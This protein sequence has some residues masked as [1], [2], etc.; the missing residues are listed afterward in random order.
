MASLVYHDYIC[1]Y[2]VKDYG[3]SMQC[4]WAILVLTTCNPLTIFAGVIVTTHE[5]NP[6][7]STL[8]APTTTRYATVISGLAD[9]AKA[10]VRELDAANDLTFLRWVRKKHFCFDY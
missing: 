5:G 3:N 4:L 10:A 8:D 2:C 9:S 1:V 7:H 6:I